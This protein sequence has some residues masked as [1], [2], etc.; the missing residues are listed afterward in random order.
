M[1]LK[2]STAKTIVRLFRTSNLNLKTRKISQ[3]TV[4]KIEKTKDRHND[5]SDTKAES[6]KRVVIK[7][8][9]SLKKKKKLLSKKYFQIEKINRL[10]IN[11]NSHSE[12]E[13]LEKFWNSSPDVYI[14]G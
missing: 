10:T 3:K 7:K 6:V 4:F 11:E 2:Y 1:N 5:Y 14:F 9:K 12:F 13:E 8:K